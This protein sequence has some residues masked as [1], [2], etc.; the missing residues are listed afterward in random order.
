MPVQVDPIPDSKLRYQSCSRATMIAVAC[1]VRRLITACVK[2]KTEAAADVVLLT[3]DSSVCGASSSAWRYIRSIAL[4]CVWRDMHFTLWHQRVTECACILSIPL[5]TS[6]SVTCTFNAGICCIRD[7]AL[8]NYGTQ[9]SLMLLWHLMNGALLAPG[10]VS[11]RDAHSLT[12][13]MQSCR[14]VHLAP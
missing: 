13:S 3:D 9:H 6:D 5:L 12:S 14:D 1:G 8:R 7:V 10:V 4:H 11:S 2:L